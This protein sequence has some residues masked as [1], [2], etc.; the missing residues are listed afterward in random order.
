MSAADPMPESSIGKAFQLRTL[1]RIITNDVFPFRIAVDTCVLAD[2]ER[3]AP[4]STHERRRPAARHQLFANSS[5]INCHLAFPLPQTSNS[6][7]PLA[8]ATPAS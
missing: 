8:A 3:H 1:R 2:T 4:F 5:C 7:S 6:S